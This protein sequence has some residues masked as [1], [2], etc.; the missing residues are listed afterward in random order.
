MEGRSR[1]GYEEKV[2]MSSD[3]TSEVKGRTERGLPFAIGSCSDVDWPWV[4]LVKEVWLA[5]KVALSF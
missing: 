2:V 3:R 1:I 5:D 4:G